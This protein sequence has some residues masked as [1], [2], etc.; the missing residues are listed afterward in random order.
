MGSKR[1]RQD[2]AYLALAIAVLAV[3]VALFVGIR[4]LP[5]GEKKPAKG[6]AVTEPEA[7]Q[8][9]GAPTPAETARDP[10]GSQQEAK[11]P[12]GLRTT[13][14]AAQDLKLIGIIQGRQPLAVIRRDSRRYYVRLGDTVRGHRVTAIGEDRVILA[15]GDEQMTLVLREPPEEDED[16]EWE[17]R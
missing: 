8:V 10:F 14:V 9:T 17:G 3:S 6:A 1:R 11:G 2:V 5:K 16:E 15:R 4:M 12:S 7:A 13:S